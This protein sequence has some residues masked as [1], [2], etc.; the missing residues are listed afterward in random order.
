V[1]LGEYEGF[2]VIED[3]M[4]YDQAEYYLENGELSPLAELIAEAE[5]TDD[6]QER[7]RLIEEMGP[8]IRAQISQ[9]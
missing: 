6:Y 8:L 1:E 3:G 7:E 2:D 9:A 4:T 5:S